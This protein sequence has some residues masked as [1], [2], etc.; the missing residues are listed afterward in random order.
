MDRAKSQPSPESQPARIQAALEVEMVQHRRYYL[1]VARRV[2][3]DEQ[4]AEEVCQQAFLLCWQRRDQLRSLEV[5]RHW[6]ARA[7]INCANSHGRQQQAHKRLKQGLAL[8]AAREQASAS[9]TALMPTE[10][11]D[12]RRRLERAIEQMPE[13]T[14]SVMRLRLLQGLKNQQAAQRV[15]IS[16]SE[17]S[18]RFY[19][20][21]DR[22]RKALHEWRD[23]V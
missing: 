22:L 1:A 17:V 23:E 2:I 7:V 9:Q 15:G 20:G 16:P 21:M 6:L 3:D 8:R 5:I 10:R 18:R 4:V 13:L 19:L 11:L 12:I 14:Q